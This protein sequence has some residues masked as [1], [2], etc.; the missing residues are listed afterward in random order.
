MSH[1]TQIILIVPHGEKDNAHNVQKIA[2]QFSDMSNGRNQG[3]TWVHIGAFPKNAG[4]M[5]H[6]T[7]IVALNGLDLYKFLPFV[8]KLLW[9]SSDEVQMF[10]K[11][12][13]D[14]LYTSYSYETGW[15]LPWDPHVDEHGIARS[16]EE[17]A[18]AEPWPKQVL[19]QAQPGGSSIPIFDAGYL[20]RKSLSDYDNA[21]EAGLHA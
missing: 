2:H 3:V 19:S 15:A 10:V 9:E 21:K 18:G 4:D 16:Y 1:V 14:E 13:G 8:G 7:Y 20:A 6:D 11:D 17:Y 5:L 12:E